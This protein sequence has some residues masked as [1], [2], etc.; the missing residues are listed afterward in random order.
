MTV[1]KFRVSFIVLDIGH[2][3]C[4]LMI[5]TGESG[6]EQLKNKRPI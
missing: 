6:N 3:L 1:I 5:C 4:L 2:Y